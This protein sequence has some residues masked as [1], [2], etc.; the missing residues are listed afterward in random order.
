MV[1]ST[2]PLCCS[3]S[4]ANQTDWEKEEERKGNWS[5]KGLQ[6]AEAIAQTFA[7]RNPKMQGSPP[8]LLQL[9][10]NCINVL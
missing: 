9:L 2:N 3:S 4:A 10:K 8:L 7:P 1:N 6:N 5:L